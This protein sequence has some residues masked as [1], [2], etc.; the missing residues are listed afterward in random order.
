MLST[1]W[2]RFNYVLKLR[3]QKS[4]SRDRN[5]VLKQYYKEVLIIQALIEDFEDLRHAGAI[6]RGQAERATAIARE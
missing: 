4:M 1:P 5:R 3:V 6:Q 2:T